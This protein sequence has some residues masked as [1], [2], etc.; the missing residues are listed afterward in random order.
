LVDAGEGDDL[1]HRYENDPDL[2][3]R[4][5]EL[6]ALRERLVAEAQ[7]RKRLIGEALAGGPAP[8][9]QSVPAWVAGR[10]GRSTRRSV[11]WPA[12]VALAAGLA[13]VLL[14]RSWLADVEP[15]SDG[16]PVQVLDGGDGELRLLAPE[17]PLDRYGEL[18][19]TAVPGGD[20]TYDLWIWEAD[21]EGVALDDLD[22]LQRE[23]GLPEPRWT[24]PSEEDLPDSILVQVQAFV[25]GVLWESSPRVW[26]SRRR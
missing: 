1:M 16:G 10:G 2:R 5:D 20:V 14:A 4:Y 6:V 24:P 9:E 7:R 21:A 26:L 19:W 3:R 13:L 25:D 17:G 11:P 22:V 15:A 23:R 8:G 18:R 12:L